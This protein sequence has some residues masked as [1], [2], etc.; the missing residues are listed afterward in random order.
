MHTFYPPACI[1]S[2][3]PFVES[4]RE[5]VPLVEV[6]VEG[7]VK[8]SLGVTVGSVLETGDVLEKLALAL[9]D[10]GL[11]KSICRCRTNTIQ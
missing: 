1:L 6:E 10:D 8:T 4:K 11:A 9:V 2:T 5:P 3:E 7:M